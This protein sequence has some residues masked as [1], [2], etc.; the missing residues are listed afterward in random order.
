MKVAMNGSICFRCLKLITAQRKAYSSDIDSARLSLG[1]GMNVER[2]CPTKR[3]D[4]WFGKMSR[5]NTTPCL[6]LQRGKLLKERGRHCWSA[7]LIW[8]WSS[9][10]VWRSAFLQLGSLA[11]YSGK[12]GFSEML[13]ISISAV[14][15]TGSSGLDRLSV[16]IQYDI[17]AAVVV[18]RLPIFLWQ[19]L[20]DG[21]RYCS[22]ISAMWHVNMMTV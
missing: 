2:W 22:L 21:P 13:I 4:R 18:P 11:L 5:S 6:L 20:L 14:S 12:R 10:L 8:N 19:T 3:V 16:P 1:S 9:S 7:N 17:T 15:R